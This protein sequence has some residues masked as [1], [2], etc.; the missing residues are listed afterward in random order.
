MERNECLPVEI[1]LDLLEGKKEALNVVLCHYYSLLI[2]K[3]YCIM[4][5]VGEEH[6][7]EGLKDVVNGVLQELSEALIHDFP[8]FYE[9][10]VELQ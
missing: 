5:D 7:L 10:Y 2:S 3:A 4:R 6:D 1:V 9:G 8:R